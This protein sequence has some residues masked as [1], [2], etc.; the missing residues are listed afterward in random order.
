MDLQLDFRAPEDVLKSKVTVSDIER[1]TASSAP[2]SCFDPERNM[3]FTPY[4]A[5]FSGFGEQAAVFALA[6]IPIPDVSKAASCVMLESDVPFEGKKYNWPIDAFSAMIGGKLRIYFLAGGDS[7]Y[8]MEW[9]PEK[10]AAENG[11][12]PVLCRPGKEAP[13][14]PLTD[15][16][17]DAFL[18]DHGCTGYDLSGDAREHIICTSKPAWGNDCFYGMITSSLA[19]PILFRCRD[20]KIFEFCG[21]V[22]VLAK[23]ECQTALLNGKI[24]ALLRGA[25]GDDFFVADEDEWIF[26]SIGKIGIAETRPQLMTYGKHLLIAYSKNDVLPN[27]IRNGRNNIRIITGSGEDLS[28]FKEVFY[29]VDEMGIVY[30]DIVNCNGDLYMIWSNSER[31]PD[32]K[33]WGVLQGK[34]TLYCSLLASRK[35]VVGTVL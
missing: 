28:T 18:K 25:D 15:K 17:V 9:S 19:Q 3:I 24:Y 20:G 14:C 30:Y 5:A 35:K 27:K 8:T 23:Y 2:I 13:V 10:S 16:V 34:D 31:F 4:H 11:I 12:S 21:I 33:V 26:R 7:Y 1:F 6:G 22:P 32:K 29:A